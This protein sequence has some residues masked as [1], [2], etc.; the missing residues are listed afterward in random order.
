MLNINKI[1]KQR[2]EL[3]KAWNLVVIAPSDY[4]KGLEGK[5]DAIDSIIDD[6]L[7]EGMD[8]A[9]ALEGIQEMREGTFQDFK[10]AATQ[11]EKSYAAGAI[12]I[13]DQ[14]IAA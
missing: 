8:E 4:V 1:N 10:Y 5:I 9:E 2:E 13:F 7:I 6:L 14:F 3:V 11:E 12:E